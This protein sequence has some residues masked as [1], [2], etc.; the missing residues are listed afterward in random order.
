MKL[1]LGEECLILRRRAGLRHCDITKPMKLSMMAL[2]LIESGK[3]GNRVSSEK[4]LKYRDY[5]RSKNVD[6]SS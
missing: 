3:P 1:T 2:S 6:I 5:L 4:A